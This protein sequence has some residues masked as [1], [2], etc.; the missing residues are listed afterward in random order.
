MNQ[1]NKRSKKIWKRL[2]FIEAKHTLSTTEIKLEF[3]DPTKTKN[4]I[5]SNKT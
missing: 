3:L 5:S 4:T 1:S 2:L